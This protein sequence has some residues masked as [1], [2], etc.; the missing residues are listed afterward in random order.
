[1][2][3]DIV[4]IDAI[5]YV[6]HNAICVPRTN[7]TIVLILY[8]HLRRRTNYL[9]LLDYTV[10]KRNNSGACLLREHEDIERHFIIT[11]KNILPCRAFS[12]YPDGS[13]TDRQKQRN[14]MQSSLKPSSKNGCSASSPSALFLFFFS[15]SLPPRL[16]FSLFR[17]SSSYRS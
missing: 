7:K 15:F 14:I 12:P 1:M 17:F 9:Q 3:S 13:R 11:N 8:V 2:Q 4:R 5:F 16:S 6:T 10:L